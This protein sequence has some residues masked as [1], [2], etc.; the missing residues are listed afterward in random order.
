MDSN[1][2]T[3]TPKRPRGKPL[4]SRKPNAR[5]EA[6]QVR[7]IDSELATVKAA[8]QATGE[9][10]SE[11]VRNAALQRAATVNLPV[12]ENPS[13]LSEYTQAPTEEDCQ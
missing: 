8:A 10:V 7:W 13:E 6:T 2:I 4:G 12:T 1:I 3:P 9:D 11:F 5:R